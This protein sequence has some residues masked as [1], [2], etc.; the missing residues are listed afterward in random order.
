[1]ALTACR[2]PSK[3][4]GPWLRMRRRLS[5]KF[6]C[7]PR[8]AHSYRGVV[9]AELLP[10]GIGRIRPRTVNE[11]DT[12][13]FVLHSDTAKFTPHSTRKQYCKSLSPSGQVRFAAR[14]ERE[15]TRI[16]G[17]MVVKG[18]ANAS[19]AVLKGASTKFLEIVLANQI[20]LHDG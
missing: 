8:S 18:I 1:M 2:S 15:L 11:A 4:S 16:D 17:V 12:Q 20:S 19:E 5:C 9:F 7:S 6:K 10:G 13:R 14:N 3:V